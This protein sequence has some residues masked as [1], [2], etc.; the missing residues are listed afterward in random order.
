MAE[1]RSTWF[2]GWWK[3]QQ[4]YSIGADGCG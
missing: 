2:N 1:K 3:L 4:V